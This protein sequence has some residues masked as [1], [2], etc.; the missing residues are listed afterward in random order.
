MFVGLCVCSCKNAGTDNVKENTDQNTQEQKIVYNDKIQNVFFG[1]PLGAT[2][3]EV[4]EGF[5]KQSFRVG[6]YSTDSRLC[7]EKVD[8][9]GY[10]VKR[11]TF[12][13]MDWDHLYVNISNNRFQS[14]EFQSAYKNKESAIDCF[15]GILS[16]VSKKYHMYEDPQADTTCYERYVGRTE[17]NQWVILQCS[18]Y[19]S[20]AH[21]R[22]IG[23]CLAYGD[24]KYDDVSDEL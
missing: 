14:I 11:Y 20:Y 12:G 24:N 6:S 21:D 15:D 5:A 17:N 10:K 23:V 7:F 2:K 9:Y 19:E 22:W 1:V 18:S 16:T 13:D 4:I 3:A 8:N